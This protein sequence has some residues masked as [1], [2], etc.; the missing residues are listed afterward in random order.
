MT[1]RIF[2]I[3]LAMLLILGSISTIAAAE[4]AEISIPDVSAL[5]GAD[6]VL[7]LTVTLEEEL[8]ALHAELV[9]STD[10]FTNVQVSLSDEAKTL[11]NLPQLNYRYDAE[12][13]R[14]IISMASAYDFG[15]AA[16]LLNIVLTPSEGIEGPY[17]TSVTLENVEVNG[18]ELASGS[19]VAAV[20]ILGS[21]R[22]TALVKYFKDGI[23]VKNANVALNGES[24]ATDSQGLAVFDDL[25]E[26][27]AE[28]LV[29]NENYVPHTEFVIG[30]NDALLVLKQCTKTQNLSAN[31]RIAADVDGNGRVN[32]M[33]ASNIL[34][35]AVGLEETF[36]AGAWAFV[37]EQK[38]VVF[39]ENGDAAVEFT[40]ILIGDVDG[41]FS[42]SPYTGEVID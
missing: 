15:C 14:L 34:K 33:D 21:Y 28:I 39:G 32:E 12:E 16:P 18:E 35:Y 26:E 27:T 20:K 41:S 31:Q 29:S 5:T 42:G 7:P 25:H 17:D 30:A 40:A 11:S 37:P 23:A 36:K 4:Q 19:M 24:K 8:F 22:L 9:V 3:V 13:G 6:V 38:T 1:K 2:S 10:E